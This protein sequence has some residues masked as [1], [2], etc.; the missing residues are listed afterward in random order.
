[1]GKNKNWIVL[2]CLL[3]TW[4]NAFSQPILTSDQREKLVQCAEKYVGTKELTNH[5]DGVVVEKIL[6]NVGL[7]KGYAW[8]AATM[9][10][11]HDD[12]GIKNPRS[13]YCPDWFK[14]HVVYQKNKVTIDRFNA[15]RGQ[16]FG[17]YIE[18]KKRVGH[19]G[20]IID[21]TRFSY[22]TIEGNTGNDSVDEGDGCY[23]K[24]RNK[25]LMYVIADYCN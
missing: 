8:C 6:R 19:E 7:G 3:W 10:I 2:V 12:A 4:G 17:L 20:M 1:M 15:K 9:A 5:N 14:T 18:S 24:I 11:A 22:V 16:V 23:K 13:A 25:R 21:Q